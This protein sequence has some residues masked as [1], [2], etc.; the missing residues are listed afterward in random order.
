MLSLPFGITLRALG[1]GNILQGKIPGPSGPPVPKPLH[2]PPECYPTQLRQLSIESTMI[3]IASRNLACRIRTVSKTHV[4]RLFLSWLLVVGI[5]GSAEAA[6]GDWFQTPETDLRIVSSVDR[7]GESQ[8]LYAGLEFELADGW[9]IY[10]RSPGEAGAPP[11]INWSASTNLKSVAMSWPKPKPFKTYGLTTYGYEGNVLFP[12]LIE[13]KRP[14]EPITLDANVQFFICSDICVPGA[15]KVTLLLPGGPAI[16]ASEGSTI[17]A[18]IRRIPLNWKRSRSLGL[19][20][21]ELRMRSGVSSAATKQEENLPTRMNHVIEI[22]ITGSGVEVLEPILEIAPGRAVGGRIEESLRFSSSPKDRGGTQSRIR[23]AVFNLGPEPPGVD[24][25][26]MLTL[27][28]GE[29]AYEFPLTRAP[30]VARGF[31]PFTS[32]DISVTRTLPE[33]L[34]TQ[35]TSPLGVLGDRLFLLQILGVALLGGLILNMMPCVLPVLALKAA[36]VAG[37]DARRVRADMLA[38]STGILI[39]FWVLAVPVI[40]LSLLDEPLGWGFQFQSPV[41][42][43]FMVALLVLFAGSLAGFFTIA[44]PD[45]LGRLASRH[46]QKKGHAGAFFLGIFA[47]LLA[48]PCTAP[49]VGTAAAAALALG[50]FGTLGLFTAMGLG[51]ASPFFVVA[52]LP[53]TVRFLPKPGSQTLWFK[54]LLA[55][56]V[57]ATA[58]WLGTILDR[59]AGIQV[60]VL[61]FLFGVVAI[62]FL[63]AGSYGA[64]RLRKIA[65]W[66]APLLV[67]AAALIPVYGPATRLGAGQTRAAFDPSE[68]QKAVAEGQ[69]VWVTITA[70][71]CLTCVYNE[72]VLEGVHEVREL[73]D[74]GSLVR[75]VGDWTLPDDTIQAYLRSFGRNGI[76]FDAVF[77]PN[78][79]SGKLLS[80]LLSRNEILETVRQAGGLEAELPA[81]AEFGVSN[82][83]NASLVSAP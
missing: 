69:V 29:Q 38:M 2:P 37:L 72:Q 18:S 19:E 58:I 56:P 35:A 63:A 67:I 11:I 26:L 1:Q 80:E 50:P 14:G 48:T 33:T 24:Q 7:V 65:P 31:M 82:T 47:T 46:V 49:F 62:A 79:P 40:I 43:A 51:M 45:S 3:H 30:S 15:G 42:V 57:L 32:T 34:G 41:F 6:S 5:S 23:T 9:K 20:P 44:T 21:L 70:D 60:A 76:P 8:G 73:E 39:G 17:E 64:K 68:I 77:G 28:G 83:F 54:R 27:L 4:G 74:R 71:W 55:L 16:P 22:D 12:L 75:I 61:T 36:G 10:W 66:V 81:L 78:L 53:Q 52:L 25:P 59:Q 13:P